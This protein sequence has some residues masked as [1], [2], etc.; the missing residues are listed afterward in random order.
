VDLGHP[1]AGLVEAEVAD[2]VETAEHVQTA[3]VVEPARV[4]G[5]EP[6]VHQRLR[7]RGWVT[8]VPL[9]QRRSADPDPPVGT[10]DEGD[11]VERVPVVD[12]PTGRLGRAVRRHHAH[13][14]RLRASTQRRIDRPTP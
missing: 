9:E 3:V 5:E 13:T 10:D 8:V 2:V 4:G 1:A 14:E 7:G 6:S 12:A 11:A